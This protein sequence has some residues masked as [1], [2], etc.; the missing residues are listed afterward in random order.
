MQKLTHLLFVAAGVGVISVAQA[1]EK[2]T[3]VDHVMPFLENACLNCHNPDEAKGGLDLTSYSAMMAGGSGG[4]VVQAGN[5]DSSRL[6]TLTAHLE[7][8]HMPPNKPKSPEKD[9]LVMKKWIEGGLL[10]TMN[11]KA[12]KSSAPTIAG[13]VEVGGKPE[14]PA[15]PE[16]LLLEPTVVTPR[17]TAVTAIATSPWAP[18]LAIGGQKQVIL[19]NTDN[20]ELLGILAFPEGF[21]EAVSFSANGS[22]LVAGGGRGGKSGLA[23]AWDVETGERVV[24][25][26]REFDTALAADI[27]PNHQF[28]TLGGP[29]RNIKIFDTTSGE[30]LHSIKKHPDWLLEAAYSPDGVLFVT[31]GR[32]GGLYVWESEAGMEFYE[33]KEHQQAITGISWRGDSNVVAVCSEDGNVSLWEMQNGK[34]IK[35]WAAHGGGA[36]SIDFSADGAQIVTSGRDNRVKI[37]DLEGKMLREIK[38][39]TD[40]VT[41]VVFTNDGKKVISGDWNGQLKVWNAADGALVGELISNPPTIAEQM[42]HSQRRVEEVKASLPKY[43]E[44]LKA[45]AVATA[46][47]KKAQDDANAQVAAAKKQKTD[48]EAVI[49]AGTGPITAEIKKAEDLLNQKNA[50]VAAK[51]ALAK[52]TPEHKK[53]AALLADEK[54]KRDSIAKNAE[55]IKNLT[56]QIAQGKKDLPDAEQ[57]AQQSAKKL[58]ETQSSIKSLENQVA[59]LPDNADL[60][61]K[62]ADAKTALPAADK[63]AKETD[64][65]YRDLGTSLQ[66]AS[67]QLASLQKSNADNDHA[68]KVAQLLI[69]E[70]K[71]MAMESE[72]K[73]LPEAEKAAEGPRKEVAAA[74]AQV[75]TLKKQLADV[76]AK[77]E[78]AKKVFAAADGVIKSKE[79]AAKA[80]GD[81]F[82][83]VAAAEATVK[84]DSEQARSDLAFMQFQV[85]KWAAAEV[86]VVLH[87]EQ[88]TL[89]S[90][91]ERLIGFEGETQDAVA[92]RDAA[93]KALNDAEITL[94]NAKKAIEDS[95]SALDTASE[96]VVEV[97][98]QL[99]AA[100]SLAEP[101][102]EAPKFEE[103]LAATYKKVEE[104][105]KKLAQ[106]SETAEKTPEVIAQRERDKQAQEQ[107]LQQAIEAKKRK[108]AEIQNQSQRVEELE[109]KYRDMYREW[110]EDTVAAK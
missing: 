84:K 42:A 10:E 18:L 97:A 45:A 109:K 21:P 104:T 39:F 88:D 93:I 74:Q 2:V 24:E 66:N 94:A 16:H 57:Q 32:N 13:T 44:S 46:A 103:T 91:R 5:P 23:V 20:L 99:V 78:A 3:Y 38:D 47:A 89:E 92:K 77:V 28:I 63:A 101:A 60:Q 86:N 31:G 58:M 37:W 108:E 41:S 110:E 102:A 73:A 69:E 27:S 15:M 26:G 1:Q 65:K 61:K 51:L 96:D 43:D 72:K 14:D 8:P 80:A 6:Y 76:Q 9:L 54:A 70:Q 105:S 50:E 100:R 30:Q 59:Q 19:Y 25:V 22:L 79:D 85:E 17:G 33:L 90:Y 48:S 35:K 52:N 82:T 55:T 71:K 11:S 83:Q 4:E 7:E 49:K 29:G 64:K 53:L 34:Q 75:E 36:L 12:K 62:F 68:I 98:L 95:K 67:N 107:A 106:A 81:K 40:V 87:K 56:A